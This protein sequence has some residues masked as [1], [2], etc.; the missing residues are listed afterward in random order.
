MKSSTCDRRTETQAVAD[1]VRQL[2][3]RYHS[4]ARVVKW[5]D[6]SE[7]EWVRSEVNNSQIAGRVTLLAPAIPR[8]RDGE[9]R[10]HAV[11]H[12]VEVE[13]AVPPLTDQ[14]Q[15]TVDV[16]PLVRHVFATASKQVSKHVI[17]LSEDH[18]INR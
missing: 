5:Y 6:I 4:V 14:R 12:V 15:R 13:V 1:I 3:P 7:M 18:L 16:S 11:R 2:V 9:E 8:T 17:Y 10:E